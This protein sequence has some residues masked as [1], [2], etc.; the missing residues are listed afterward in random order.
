VCADGTVQTASEKS[1][2]D[3]FWAIRGGG[4]NFGIATSLT[5]RLHPHGPTVA[6]A[7]VFYPVSEADTVWR[8]YRDWAASA[9]DEVSTLAG[10]TTLPAHPG[11]PP[12]VHDTPFVVIGA[13]YSGDPEKGMKVLQPLRELGK[14]LADISGPLPFAAVQG[15]F[16]PF[17][18]RGTLRSYWKST[19]VAKM[20]DEVLD[21]VVR[22]S[23]ERP[24]KRTFVVTFLMGGA[25]NRVGAE[26]TAYSERSADWMVSLDGNWE[27][28]A[29]DDKVV[30]WIRDAW[31]EV[32]KLGTGT[33]YLNFTSL[34]GDPTDVG[35]ESAYGKNLK[36][37]G[38]IKAKYDPDNFF[39]LNNNITPAGS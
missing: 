33:T 36:R 31:A 15:A 21:I 29:D 19:Y 9:P 3:L 39:R 4:G 6:F 5:F 32:H 34:A 11:L 38:R 25:I 8:K 12:E 10:C 18:V 30:R 20:T 37:L 23:T 13:I 14:P 24:S 28:P 17:F 1:N 35:V 22:R 2:P 26:D 7:G 16:D 27:Q